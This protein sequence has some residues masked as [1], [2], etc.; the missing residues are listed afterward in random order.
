MNILKV[1]QEFF[2]KIIHV[3]KFL[4][5]GLCLNRRENTCFNMESCFKIKKK[6]YFLG[7]NFINFSA[8]RVKSE[9]RG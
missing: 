4:T 6:D 5:F 9:V 3:S 2:R 1:S 7:F 8:N